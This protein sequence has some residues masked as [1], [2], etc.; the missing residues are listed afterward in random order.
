MLT[1]LEPNLSAVTTT[2]TSSAPCRLGSRPRRKLISLRNGGVIED[3][4]GVADAHTSGAKPFGRNDY[5]NKFRTLSAGLA[6]QKEIDLAQEWRGDRGRAWR[7]RCS[8]VWSQTF[9][10]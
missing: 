6:S 7:R 10:P 1:R 4:L 8:H 5:I 3:E 2:S 9:R